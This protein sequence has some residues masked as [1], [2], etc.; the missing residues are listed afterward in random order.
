MSRAD[1]APPV[2]SRPTLFDFLVIVLG[3]A[4]SLFLCR[5]EGLRVIAAPTPPSAVAA[6]LV[7]ILPQLLRL[8]EGVILLWPV[9]LTTQRLMGRKQG[10]TSAEWLWVV[11]WLAVV[12]LTALSAWQ[13]SGVGPEFLRE[14]LPRAF[15]LG[16]LILVPSMAAVALVLLLLGVIGRWRQ[17]WTHNFALALLLWPALPVAGILAFTK[18]SGTAH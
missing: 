12:V 17:P 2:V 13:A 1:T 7:P 6:Y 18:I 16:Y 14:Q 4:L 9:F 3:F 5:L 11:A 10:L 15:V 8:P